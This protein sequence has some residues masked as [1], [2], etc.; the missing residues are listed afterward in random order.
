MFTFY[1][2]FSKVINIS[3]TIFT[4]KHGCWSG[5]YRKLLLTSSWVRPKYPAG[6]NLM[7]GKAMWG[8]AI[9]FHQTVKISRHLS[10]PFRSLWSNGWTGFW[11]SGLWEQPHR[12]L[13]YQ[14]SDGTFLQSKRNIFGPFPAFDYDLTELT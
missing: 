7:A 5:V 8:W 6:R 9:V 3:T 11:F 12:I 1:F 2:S 4:R 13:A 14:K 10:E